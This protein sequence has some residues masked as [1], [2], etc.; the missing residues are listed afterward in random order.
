MPLKK[1]ERLKFLQMGRLGEDRKKIEK[2]NNE[3]FT[4]VL[5]AFK[6]FYNYVGK[7]LVNIYGNTGPGNEK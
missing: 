5:P 3:L 6:M 1:G 4:A 2:E 7:E